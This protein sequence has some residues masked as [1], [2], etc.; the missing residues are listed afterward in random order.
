MSINVT[1][2]TSNFTPSLHDAL[3]IL[4]DRADAPEGALARRSNRR[5]IHEHIHRVGVHLRELTQRDPT[6][7]LD[8]HVEADVV[9]RKST[10]L[11]SSH[12]YN[13]YAVFS[14]KKNSTTSYEV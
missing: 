12:G 6:A 5:P 9:D 4:L 14:L 3:P 10:R 7:A 1:A 11:N 2:T 13:S 8:R